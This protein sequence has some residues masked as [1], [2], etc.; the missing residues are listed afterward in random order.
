M[1]TNPLF[2]AAAALDV[3]VRAVMTAAAN[4]P[5]G[6]NDL[7]MRALT[8]ALDAL[9]AAIE[10]FKTVASQPY[11]VTLNASAGPAPQRFVPQP[12]IPTPET[13]KVQGGGL[14]P[15]PV[16]TAAAIAER[17]ENLKRQL[18]ALG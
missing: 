16:L 3:A 15:A 14:P 6:A 12:I 8:G 5:V 2:V 7:R 9:P 18:A 10:A 13:A 17:R 11:S 1:A 4:T